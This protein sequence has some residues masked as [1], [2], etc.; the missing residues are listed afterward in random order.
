VD[1]R[2]YAKNPFLKKLIDGS[3]DC[4]ELLSHINFNVSIFQSHSPFFFTFQFAPT[5]P[6]INPFL[7]KC[8]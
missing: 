4:T 3:I 8:V 1:R 5:I 7:G 6:V 2:I